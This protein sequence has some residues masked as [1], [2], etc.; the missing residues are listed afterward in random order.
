MGCTGAARLGVEGLA[1]GPHSARAGAR[2]T[3]CL[4]EEL[5]AGTLRQRARTEAGVAVEA[6]GG[7]GSGVG[8]PVGRRPGT[9]QHREAAP[10]AGD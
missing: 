7:G 3:R 4:V 10:A 2:K 1:P 9:W 8:A 6:L 5:G